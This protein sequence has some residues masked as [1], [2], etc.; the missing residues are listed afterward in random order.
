MPLA[1][2]R[3]LPTD[4]QHDPR[5]SHRNPQIP[6]PETLPNTPP[7]PIPQ[8]PG[9]PLGPGTRALG[10]REGRGASPH[11]EGVLALKCDAC[12]LNH[13]LSHSPRCPRIAIIMVMD[14]GLGPPYST[15]AGDQDDVSQTNSLEL[16]NC[17]VAL[18]EFARLLNTRKIQYRTHRSGF[19]AWGN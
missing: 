10:Y 14:S 3:S 15:R 16:Q 7:T 5:N 18:A 1:M 19:Q 4:A 11:L 13:D 2:T 17:F 8:G 12:A 6:F 9:R